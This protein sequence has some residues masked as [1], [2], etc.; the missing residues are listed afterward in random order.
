MKLY[1]NGGRREKAE[2]RQAMEPVDFTE[3]RSQKD[4]RV[5][6]DRRSGIERRNPNGFRVIAGMDRRV[7][8]R[9]NSHYY[10]SK[11]VI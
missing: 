3:R 7:F 8:Y 5:R 1:D 2:R 11:M 6:S 9:W 4:R 10:L